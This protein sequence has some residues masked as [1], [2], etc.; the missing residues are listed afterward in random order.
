MGEVEA[1]FTGLDP[2]QIVQGYVRFLPRLAD[3]RVEIKGGRERKIIFGGVSRIFLRKIDR[4]IYLFIFFEVE[5][6]LY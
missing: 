4:S 1:R 5:R 3:F 6:I 2:G